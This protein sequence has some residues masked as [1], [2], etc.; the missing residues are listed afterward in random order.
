VKHLV[1][2]V[3]IFSI[4]LYVVTSPNWG[5]KT[6][7]I[8]LQYCPD[9]GSNIEDCPQNLAIMRQ[10][11]LAIPES[12]IVVSNSSF[13]T[14]YADCQVFDSENWNCKTENDKGSYGILM[15]EGAYYDVE[16]SPLEKLK[17]LQ[18]GRPAWLIYRLKQFKRNIF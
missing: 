2:T 10:T 6:R 9:I 18:V 8:Y 5:D 15:R 17:I 3:L 7:T 4:I 11:F 1:S 13:V 16:S 14:K 12:Q